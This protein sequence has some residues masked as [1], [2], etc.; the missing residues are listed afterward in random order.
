MEAYEYQFL[1]YS[2]A[3]T[4]DDSAQTS[5]STK[6][7][8]AR[9]HLNKGTEV[10]NNTGIEQTTINLYFL[11]SEIGTIWATEELAAI[12]SNHLFTGIM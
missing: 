10:H 2:N 7:S 3:D 5:T 12:F 8:S 6:N 9:F 1:L 11:A 4:R